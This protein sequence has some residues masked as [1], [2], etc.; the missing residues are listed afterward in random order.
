MMEAIEAKRKFY[1]TEF[2]TLLKN[3]KSE[4]LNILLPKL[5]SVRYIFHDKLHKLKKIEKKI[6]NPSQLE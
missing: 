3:R 1:E 2:R 4:A 6:E 5:E